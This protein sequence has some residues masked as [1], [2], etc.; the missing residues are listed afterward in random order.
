VD[1]SLIKYLFLLL[2]TSVAIFAVTY[3]SPYEVRLLLGGLLVGTV[4][5]EA[6]TLWYPRKRVP[7]LRD[8]R[9]GLI[10]R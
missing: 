4:A 5:H 9:T 2:A 3:V 8:N 1:K 10:R 7:R 6:Y